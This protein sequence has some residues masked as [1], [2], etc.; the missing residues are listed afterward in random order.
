MLYSPDW[1]ITG[2]SFI[3]LTV[4]LFR[5]STLTEQG[6][7]SKVLNLLL[8]NIASSCEKVL[9]T[10]LIATCIRVQSGQRLLHRS[11]FSCGMAK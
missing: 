10:F 3:L 5:H 7:Y 11:T 1:T 9:M 4:N 8:L 6:L 2:F